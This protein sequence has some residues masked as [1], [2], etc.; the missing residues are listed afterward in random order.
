MQA[1]ARLDCLDSIPASRLKQ[2]PLQYKT[3]QPSENRY[4]L[5]HEHVAFSIV[6]KDQCVESYFTNDGR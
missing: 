5:G 6:A 1:R 4:S 3:C 2:K